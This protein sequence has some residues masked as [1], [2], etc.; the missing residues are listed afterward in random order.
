[1]QF[2]FHLL[3]IIAVDCFVTANEQVYWG[4]CVGKAIRVGVVIVAN[5]FYQIFYQQANNCS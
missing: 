3:Q 1:M 2:Y 5:S 4:L